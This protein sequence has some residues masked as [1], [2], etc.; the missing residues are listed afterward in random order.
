[1]GFGIKIDKFAALKILTMKKIITL[2]ACIATS[3]F[4]NAQEAAQDS[5]NTRKQGWTKGGTITFLLNQ[6]SFSNWVAGGDNN[7]AGNV[8][9]NYDFNFY[10]GTWTWDNKIILA[11]GLS[12][13]GSQDTRKSDDRIELNS[14]AGKKAWG[15]W[16]YSAFVNFRTQ[17]TDGFD[18]DNDGNA[19]FRTSGLFKPA[20]LTFGP[21]MLWQKH[22]N[23]KV[24]LA[25]VTSKMTFLSG[26]VFTFEDTD[27]DGTV[28]RLSSNNRETFGVDAG[29]SF[30]YELGF[31]ASGYYK[32]NLMKN[33]SIENILN[34]YSNYLED[35]QNVDIDYTMNA[36]MQINKYLSTNITFQT[37]YDD[38]LFQGF[39]TRQLFG[40]GVNLNF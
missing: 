22:E 25:P 23:L 4:L 7:I 3:L 33:V 1:M 2:M 38:N 14:L 8:G 32:F 34:L 35:P 5:A 21:G 39:Q 40:L 36:I 15:N 29:E 18:Y 26:E 30:R 28:E 16:N 12:K 13:T 10:N 17:F 24:N 9:V 20:I 27:G 6:N 19:D 31:Y 11:Y 37:I